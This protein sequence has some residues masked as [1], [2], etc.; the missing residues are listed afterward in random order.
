MAKNSG[1]YTKVFSN[2]VRLT[3]DYAQALVASQVDE[4]SIS[5]H[6]ITP[7]EVQATMGLKKYEEMFSN[8]LF[9]RRQLNGSPTRMYV[10]YNALDELESTDEEIHRFWSEKGIN[11]LGPYPVWN[12]AGQLGRLPT[13][14]RALFPSRQVNFNH[15]A[16]CARLSYFD[17]IAANGDYV[18]CGCGFFAKD[19]PVLGNVHFDAL[20][21]VHAAYQDVLKRKSENAMCRLCVKPSERYVMSEILDVLEENKSVRF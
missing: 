7:R 21:A 9:L 20:S 5:C 10:T 13:Q 12:R 19:A 8:I 6:G 3:R 14:R 17:S 11:C 16:W 18:Y 2:A 4:I 1:F 15:R